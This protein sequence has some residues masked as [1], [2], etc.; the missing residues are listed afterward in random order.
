[1]IKKIPFEIIQAVRGESPKK[2]AQKLASFFH[3]GELGLTSTLDEVKINANYIK[4][5]EYKVKAF[6]V[7]MT[8]AEQ[9]IELLEGFVNVHVPVSYPMG[10]MMLDTKL[11]SLDYLARLEVDETCVCLNYFNILSQNYQAV[12]KEA[13]TLISNYGSAFNPFALVVPSALLSDSEIIDICKAL[14]TAGCNVLKLNPGFHLNVTP[15]EVALVKR[16]FPDTFEI[17]P[18]GGIRNLSDVAEYLK[19]NITTIH[20]SASK[21]IVE[22]FLELR[23]EEV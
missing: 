15:E 5:R 19:L 12:E 13:E 14:K 21:N 8:Q 22:N 23:K 9:V 7:E 4:E 11:K 20:S 2:E 18:S 16:V 10:N 6:N 17:H 3:F 1:M